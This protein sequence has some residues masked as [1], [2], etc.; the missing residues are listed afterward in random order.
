MEFVGDEDG[1]ASRLSD[2]RLGREEAAEAFRQCVEN[3][4]LIVRSG[5]VHGDYSTFNVL[6]WQ[7]KAIVIDF[8]QVV[9]LEANPAAAQILRRDVE[10]LC[11]SFGHFGLHPDPEA[12]LRQVKRLARQD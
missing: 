5:R 10:G 11:R 4:A 9:E 12:T 3:L 2:A 8:P 6:W 7:E 1:A